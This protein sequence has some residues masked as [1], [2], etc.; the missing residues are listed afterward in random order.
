MRS[1]AFAVAA[2]ALLLGSLPAVWAQHH[3]AES[4]MNMSPPMTFHTSN[5]TSNHTSNAIPS[6]YSHEAYSGL[7]LAHIALMA[8]GWVFI[9]PIGKH[10]VQKFPTHKEMKEVME[11][12]WNQGVM[13]S[14]ARSRY[15]LPLQF[16][17]LVV[18]ALGVLLVTIY[19]SNTP[20]LYPNNSHHKLGW[21][22]TWIMSAQ[23]CMALISAY[24]GRWSRSRSLAYMPVSTEA[25]AEHQRIHELRP[26]P[27][28]RYSNDSGHGTESNTESLRSGSSSSLNRDHLPDLNPQ[29]EHDD[30]EEK[31]QFFGGSR[32][33]GYLSSK[34]SGVFSNNALR[35][36]D[37][38]YNVIDRLI[39]ILGFVALTS[40]FVTYGG[41]FVSGDSCGK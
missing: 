28:P 20:D 34:I 41:I 31:Q 4:E 38:I 25:M 33:D 30:S 14:I 26:K 37:T 23:T 40:G 32:V 7:M 15:S 27:Q 5:M 29:Y 12:D 8:I 22:L 19:N 35:I 1:S 6:Y 17:F 21:A 16:L 2:S 36:F 9:L 39:L 24:S 18:N 13:L 3:H 10:P 11:T